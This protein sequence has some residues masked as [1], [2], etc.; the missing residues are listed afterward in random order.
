MRSTEDVSRACLIRFLLVLLGLWLNFSRCEKDLSGLRTYE[1]YREQASRPLWGDGTVAGE[2]SKWQDSVCRGS[3]SST[4]RGLLCSNSAPLSDFSRDMYWCGR[5]GLT[6][7]SLREEALLVSWEVAATG[8]RQGAW[9]VPSRLT[10]LALF[11]DFNCFFGPFA[12]VPGIVVLATA[13]DLS[14]FHLKL[15]ASETARISPWRLRRVSF[16]GWGWVEEYVPP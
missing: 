1:I 14:T 5:R 2:T 10:L 7:N 4:H 9:A 13:G 15:W 3:V 12:S 16:L 8:K 11:V 6:L